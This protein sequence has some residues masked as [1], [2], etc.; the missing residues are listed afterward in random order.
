MEKEDKRNRIFVIVILIILIILIGLGIWYFCYVE[1]T[2][3][4][5]FPDN[6]AIRI[7]D[8]DTFQLFSGETVR[9]I[10]VD[11]PES[12]SLKGDEATAYLTSLIY[13]KEVRLESDVDDKDAY[14][15]LLRY[16]YV[17]NEDG[18]IFVNKEIVEQ[19]YADVFRYGNDTRRC[20]EISS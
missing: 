9:L 2:D 19:G 7:I 4:A 6:T 17:S 16:V 15:R 18:E 14:G 1:N 13:F 11:A 20:D 8:G 5:Y 12:G 3:Y 10:C